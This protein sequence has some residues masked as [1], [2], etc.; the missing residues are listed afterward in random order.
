MRYT[1]IYGRQLQIRDTIL[2]WYNL[3]GNMKYS[4]GRVTNMHE[5]K[6]WQSSYVQIDRMLERW[7]G[8]KWK[9]ISNSKVRLTNPN[10]L[11]VGTEV[12]IPQ[13]TQ[14]ID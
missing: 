4:I 6:A 12:E 3:H 1:S 5:D 10:F 11:V 13:E 7:V 9:R 8:D 14:I 2:Y